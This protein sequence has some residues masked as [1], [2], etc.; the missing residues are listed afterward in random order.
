MPRALL[1]CFLCALLLLA[2]ASTGLAETGFVFNPQQTYKSVGE[3]VTPVEFATPIRCLDPAGDQLFVVFDSHVPAGWFAQFCL[4]SSGMCYPDDHSITLRNDSPDTLR[5]DFHIPAGLVGKGY[6]DVRIYRVAD[7]L[8][9]KEATFA[10]GHGETLPVPA[11]TFRCD[12]AF[13]EIEPWSETEFPAEIRSFNSF[14]DSLIV[15]IERDVPAGWVAQW[16][17][18]STGQ[19][20]MGTRKIKFDAYFIDT[21]RVDFLCYS[22]AVAIGH[23]RMKTQSNANPAIWYALPFRVRT[24]EI[25][26]AAEEQTG[27][28]APEVRV[29]PNPVRGLADIEINLSSPAAVHVTMTDVS[30]R[31]VFQRTAGV[32]G[33]GAQRI[34]WDGRDDQGRDLP[35]GVYFYRVEGAGMEARGKVTID[36]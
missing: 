21:L 25:P 16:C 22:S 1:P 5:F 8:Y 6:I 2:G 4:V 32:L 35:G 24:G 26:A 34:R 36:R 23:V 33:P 30:G 3:S 18:T 29:I 28:S 17:Q 19:C 11:Y 27:A 20:Y 12:Q 15:Q 31:V 9:F 10:V 14:N 7:P 13:Q